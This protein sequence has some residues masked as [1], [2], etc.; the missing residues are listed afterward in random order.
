[1]QKL[2][3][4]IYLLFI[5]INAGIMIVEATPTGTPLD[6]PLVSPLDANS[7]VTSVSMPAIYQ[8]NHC[9]VNGDIDWTIDNSAACGTA[10]GV[11]TVVSGTLA[12]D[13]SDDV[14]QDHCTVN[15]EVDWSIT[16]QTDCTTAG[17]AWSTDLDMLTDNIFYPFAIFGLFVN[18]L[19]GGF[20]WQ[21]FAV[22]GFP[23]IF[24]GVMQSVIGLLL[25]I[26]IV[27][28]VTGR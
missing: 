11:W 26:T 2:F 8:T 3:L 24:V 23:S 1:M 22:F 5:C 7:T 10:S 21:L 20:I 16:T 4:E 18:F 28:Y 27:Y 12:Q 14:S 9:T 15:N 25:V 19:T 6:I 13:V 17:G